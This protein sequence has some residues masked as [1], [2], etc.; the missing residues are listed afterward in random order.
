[1]KEKMFGVE[2][3]NLYEF[4]EDKEPIDETT[5]AQSSSRVNLLTTNLTM[6]SHG[7]VE[8]TNQVVKT[9]REWKHLQLQ[10]LKRAKERLKENSS[11]RKNSSSETKKVSSLSEAELGNEVL[12]QKEDDGVSEQ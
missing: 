3:I 2:D 10:E 1:M 6:G 8:A 4:V 12:N 7:E 5:I 11:K 9:T